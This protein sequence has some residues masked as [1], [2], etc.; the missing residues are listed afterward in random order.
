MGLAAVAVATTQVTGDLRILLGLIVPISLALSKWLTL[1]C[2]HFE[3]TTERVKV[4]R[5]IFSRQREDLE[6]YRV[7]DTTLE[8]P[9]LLRLVGRGSVHI[10]S[11]DKTTPVTVIPAIAH[12]EALRE[13]IRGQVERLRIARGVREVDYQ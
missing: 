4:T 8:E 9:F 7:K 12:A 2:T 10:S 11:S 5:G 1:R 3:V 13:Q 6:L